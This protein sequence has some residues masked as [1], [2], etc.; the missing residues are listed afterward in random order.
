MY[1]EKEEHQISMSSRSPYTKVAYHKNSHLFLWVRNRDVP[2]N[3]RMGGT[4]SMLEFKGEVQ[5]VEALPH[6]TNL[7]ENAWTPLKELL[8]VGNYMVPSTKLSGLDK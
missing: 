2:W 6:L 7:E 1:L 4:F 5:R 3:L 8:C